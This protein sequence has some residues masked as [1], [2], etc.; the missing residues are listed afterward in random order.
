VEV[1][2]RDILFGRVF[3][4]FCGDMFELEGAV[5]AISPVCT[6]FAGTAF[7]LLGK[8]GWKNG[9]QP[10]ESRVRLTSDL[11]DNN[12]HLLLPH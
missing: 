10:N 8:P 12:M 5:F 9:R 1:E 3:S 6:T 11:H 4:T 7:E 2:T